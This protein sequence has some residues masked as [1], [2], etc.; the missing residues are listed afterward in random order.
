LDDAYLYQFKPEE[1][2]LVV[3]ASNRQK[4]WD[5]LAR[6]AGFEDTIED[7]TDRLAMMAVQGP[8]SEA[9]LTAAGVEGLPPKGRGRTA[10]AHWRSLEVLVSRTGYTGEPVGFELM[11]PADAVNDFWAALIWNGAPRGILPAG[12]GARDT[13]RLEIGLPLY[14]HELHPERPALS[15]PLARRGV[16]LDPERGD[17]QGREALVAQEAELASGEVKDVPRMIMKVAAL[18]RGMVRE[19]STVRFQGRLIGELTSGTMVPAWK[20]QGDVP[21]EETFTRALALAYLDRD[22]GP[23]DR[24]T[25]EYRGREIQGEIVTRFMKPEGDYLRALQVRN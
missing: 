7:V 3:N 4:D 5:L 13:L 8:G 17:F 15:L 2:I 20:F 9:L 21:G 10:V 22:C 12:L 24:V 18:E 6:R 1:Y 23:G 11:L 16:S 19:G 14:G 25:I